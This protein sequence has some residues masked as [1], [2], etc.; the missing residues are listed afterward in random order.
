MSIAN[1][2]PFS[3]FQMTLVKSKYFNSV[4]NIAVFT[5]GLY[6]QPYFSFLSFMNSL[7]QL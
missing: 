5:P 6:V 7:L 2:R 3:D 1:L 4:F